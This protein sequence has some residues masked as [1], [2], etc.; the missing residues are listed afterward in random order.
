M[1]EVGPE[2]SR[3]MRGIVAEEAPNLRIGEPISAT[4]K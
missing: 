3:C 2:L 4:L 1:R